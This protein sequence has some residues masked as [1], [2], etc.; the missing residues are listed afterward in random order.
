[1]L[2]LKFVFAFLNH[3][4]LIVDVDAYHVD[5]LFHRESKILVIDN[6][7]HVFD[8]DYYHHLNFHIQNVIV[9]F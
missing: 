4:L 6:K 8:N 5:E 9:L 1:M 2:D 7:L 3:Q